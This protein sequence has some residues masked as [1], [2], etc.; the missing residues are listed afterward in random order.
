MMART[1]FGMLSILFAATLPGQ[2]DKP[3]SQDK[4][5]AA[6]KAIELE[7]NINLAVFRKK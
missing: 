3:T 6:S 4:A 1:T 5:A 7:R 2:T